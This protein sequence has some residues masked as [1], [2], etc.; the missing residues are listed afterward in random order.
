[1]RNLI[2]GY[3]RLVY[4]KML[5]LFSCALILLT[6]CGLDITDENGT[7]TPDFVTAT[8]PETSTPAATVTSIPPSP[9]PT[10]SPV[11]GT[12]T[13]QINV[14]S[15]PSTVGSSLGIIPPFSKVQILGRESNSAWYQIIYASSPDG[16]GWVTA[17]YVQV[18]AA[19]EIPVIEMGTG[20]GA[21]VSGLVIR[22]I[23]VRSGPGTSY[24][25]LGTLSPN[26]VVPVTGRDSSGAWMQIEFKGAAGWAASE[27]MQVDGADALPV[28]AETTQVIGTA[29][30]T[31]I[32]GVSSPSPA[33]QDNDSQQEPAASLVLSPGG[34]HA[35]QFSGNVSSP[36][37]DAADWLQFTSAGSTLL[38][39]VKCSN[40]GLNVELWN[41]GQHAG[42]TFS[43][44]DTGILE[45]EA[46]Q[47]Y[48]LRMVASE[49]EPLQVTEY[50]L[51]LEFVR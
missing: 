6:S 28:T 13:T 10:A 51:K 39:E 1:M 40:N 23:N 38:L 26:D 16:K 2:L 5:I 30:A 7:P 19:V 47:T 18:D 8:L 4:Q 24:E 36:H 12:T 41:N 21:G 42:K 14:R 22:P 46:G 44:A 49:S 43:C 15:E 20:S 17:T 34:A 32:A 33:V 37:G 45:I 31:E 48:Y 11:E 3:N 35:F 50:D 27:F 25:S 9:L 29:P